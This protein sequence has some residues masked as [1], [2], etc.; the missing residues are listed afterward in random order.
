MYEFIIT[1]TSPEVRLTNE[2]HNI[3][4][5]IKLFHEHADSGLFDRVELMDSRTGEV[6]A[7]TN[8]KDEDY[9]LSEVLTT[10]MV[11][12][13]IDMMLGGVPTPP[14]SSEEPPQDDP[15]EAML[16]AIVEQGGLPS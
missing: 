15:L 8:G 12:G 5:A 13:M 3:D 4:F 14:P 2:V 10:Y 6:H 1:A 11:V 9:Y 16:R 7:H